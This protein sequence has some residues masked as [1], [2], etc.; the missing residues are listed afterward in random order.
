MNPLEPPAEVLLSYAP[1]DAEWTESWLLPHLEKQGLNVFVINRDLLAGGTRLEQLAQLA[2]EARHTLLVLSPAWV[3]SQLDAFTGLISLT[4]DPLGRQRKTIPLLRQI[5]QPPRSIARLVS[6]DFTSNQQGEWTRQFTRLVTV[7]KGQQY[8]TAL[9]PPLGALLGLEAP[10]NFIYPKNYHFVGREQELAQLHELLDEAIILGV[11][12]AR[13]DLRQ[14]PNLTGLTG[15][16]GVGKTQ[17]VVEYIYRYRQAYPG[18]VFWINAADG[19]EE[20][21]ASIGRL[22]SQDGHKKNNTELV[23]MAADYLRSDP[24]TLLVLDNLNDPVL[25]NQ[26]VAGTVVPISI[27]CRVL[28]TTR[29]RDLRGVRAISVD[30]LA[31][32]DALKLLLRSRRELLKTDHAEHSIAIKVCATLGGLPLAIDLAASYLEQEPEITLAGYLQR[33][34]KYGTLAT[35][36]SLEQAKEWSP[37]W[38]DPVQLTLR[39]QWEA[40]RDEHA[41]LLIQAAAL[42]PEAEAVPV[43]LL[44]L[45]TGFEESAEEG[46]PSP[47]AI[48]QRQLHNYSLIEELENGKQVRLHPLVREFVRSQIDDLSAFAQQSCTN[49]TAALE[50]LQRVNKEINV[51]GVDALLADLKAGLRLSPDLSALEDLRLVL[52]KEAHNLRRTFSHMFS[53]YPLQQIRKRA[54]SLGKTGLVIR[55]EDALRV[56]KAPWFRERFP[57]DSESR[58]QLRTFEGHERAVTCV[59]IT[60]D[61]KRAV[62]GSV[63][64]TLRLWDLET[65]QSLHTFKGHT[66]LVTAVTITPDGRR[67][68]SGSLDNTLRLWDL[69]SGQCLHTFNG[70]TDGVT[71][72]AIT[73]DGKRALSGSSDSTLRL[74][75]LEGQ[76]SLHTFKGHTAG[77]TAVVI[78]PDGKRAISASTDKSLRMWNLKGGRSL[79]TLEGHTGPVTAVAITPN[80]KHAISASEDKS[81]RLWDLKGGRNLRTFEGHTGPITTVAIS[82]DGKDVLSAASG[83]GTLLLWDLEQELLHLWYEQRLPD[84]EHN[85]EQLPHRFRH[86]YGVNAVTISPDGKRAISASRDNTLCVWDLKRAGDPGRLW[87]LEEDWSVQTFYGHTGSVTAVAVTPDGKRALSGSSDGTLRLWD[88]EGE[89]S[90]QTFEGHPDSVIAVAI[91]PDGKRAISAS[92]TSL[93][94]W[95]LHNGK[96]QRINDYDGFA[97]CLAFTSNGKRAISA[98]TNKLDVLSLERSWLSRLFSSGMVNNLHTFKESTNFATAVAITPDGKRAISGTFDGILLLWDLK[99]GQHL[100]TFGR[101]TRP[102]TALAVTSDG[103][104][105]VS[106]HRDNTLRLWDFESGECRHIFEGHTAPVTAV[107]ITSDGKRALSA[108]EDSTLRLWDLENGQHLRTL[109][110]HTDV[111]T[112]VAL[113]PNGQRAISASADRSLCLWDLESGQALSSFVDEKFTVVTIHKAGSL[114]AAGSDSGV[115]HFIDIIDGDGKY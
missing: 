41:R 22:L 75:D 99:H 67:A 4:S 83:D 39:S 46:F 16:G 8:R 82:P 85:F 14:G 21:F 108:S 112:H 78:T 80:G 7:L 73:P 44:S 69:E 15:L 104:H 18:G 105:A 68:I 62:S 91:P 109:E 102:V 28:F 30:V 97:E 2:S 37:T 95:E 87:G 114:V 101:H 57:S 79:R 24:E 6:A 103:K 84:L 66:M 115:V 35:V 40:I 17:L 23:Q 5:C 65:G 106:A 42:M 3:K 47:I 98:W 32:T 111:A 74:W 12:A 77:V 60:P 1:A 64:S 94:V 96:N 45:L 55:I 63:D 58:A 93:Y 31:E 89:E 56:L 90:P 9:G 10:T 34:A 11:S 59:V 113:A 20:G 27:P 61:G 100:A 25:L 53:A 76:G 71:V 110:A 19:L 88:L 33:L 43:S 26:P 13:P 48:G 38:H 86:R 81:L 70:H 50:D 92:H 72:V 52:D 54:F 51:R 36:D 107:A 49:M 29:R